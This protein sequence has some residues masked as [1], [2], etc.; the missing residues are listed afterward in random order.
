MPFCYPS[1]KHSVVETYWFDSINGHNIHGHTITNLFK[2]SAN[3]VWP[4]CI[5]QGAMI[6]QALLKEF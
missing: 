6:S 4:Q 1:N 2:L 5:R 3:E